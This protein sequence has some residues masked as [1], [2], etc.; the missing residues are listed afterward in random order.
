MAFFIPL[1]RSKFPSGIIFLL[2]EE[3]PL[4]FLLKICCWCVLSAFFFFFFFAWR[5]LCSIFV[6]ERKDSNPWQMVPNQVKL[7]NCPSFLSCV[8]RPQH[9]RVTWAEPEGVL[10][11]KSRETKV[12]WVHRTT[13]Y[14]RGENWMRLEKGG[15]PWVFST[16]PAAHTYAET[17]GALGQSIQKSKW[18]EWL[19]LTQCLFLQTRLEKPHTHGREYSAVGIF[20]LSI[21]CCSGCT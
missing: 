20:K 14:Q 17:T 15:G 6:F 21:K 19:S 9:R 10:E 3:L 7:N 12:V 2:P 18:E 1:G 5:S 4:T 11:M 16:Y 8:F 13:T